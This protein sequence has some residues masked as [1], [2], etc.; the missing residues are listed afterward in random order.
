MI[1]SYTL[2]YGAPLGGSSRNITIPFGVGKP[3]WWGYPMVKNVWRY[4]CNRLDSIPACDGRTDRRTSCDGIVRAMH[5]RRAV[6]IRR[7]VH[8]WL[9]KS[10]VYTE[11]MVCD[12]RKLLNVKAET[13][14]KLD[15]KRVKIVYRLI[16]QW[17]HR[18]GHGVRV[19]EI[20]QKSHKFLQFFN[21]T[22][23]LSFITPKGTPLR[24]FRSFELS[25]VKIHQ[26]VW[27][28]RESEKKN[29]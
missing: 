7:P 27:P 18:E 12:R 6:K 5:T 25:R 14:E 8:L 15:V 26:L 1:F 22:S 3:V 9:W 20:R 4:I 17:R 10:L 23:N 11:W 29:V 28:V 16:I 24:D 13:R 2:A 19:H 21:L